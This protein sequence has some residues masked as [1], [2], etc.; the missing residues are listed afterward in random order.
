MS[1]LQR[2]EE[3][4]RTCVLRPVVWAV[5]S[6]ENDKIGVSDH[7]REVTK[8]IVPESGSTGKSG[9]ICR[10]PD[11]SDLKSPI[12]C[13]AH[14]SALCTLRKRKRPRRTA[15]S[16]SEPHMPCTIC[17]RV[18]GCNSFAR[19]EKTL[20]F[21]QG[22]NLS[23]IFRAFLPC[24]SPHISTEELSKTDSTSAYFFSSIIPYRF[25][26]SMRSFAS[27]MEPDA[28]LSAPDC[29]PA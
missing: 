5:M 22:L 29:S 26:S 13:T 11:S 25:I 6:G 1:P 27:L 4:R 3:G 18:E 28:L 24:Q 12:R 8:M 14:R 21:W 9:T 2:G 7:F 16:H 19:E 20:R 10:I 15:Q 17:R 23:E